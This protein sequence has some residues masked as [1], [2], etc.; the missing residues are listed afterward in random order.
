MIGFI[1]DTKKIV[2]PNLKN[3]YPLENSF[4]DT[5]RANQSLTQNGT[6]PF[7]TRI[8]MPDGNKAAGVFSDANYLSYT[9]AN[10]TN[11]SSYFI[12]MLVHPVSQSNDPIMVDNVFATNFYLQGSN[13]NSRLQWTWGTQTNTGA[14]TFQNGNW[15]Y[16]A[17]H[18]VTGSANSRLWLS[19]AN[20]IS[21]TPIATTNFNQTIGTCSDSRF[22]RYQPS[23]GFAFNGYIKNIGVAVNYSPTRL[24]LNRG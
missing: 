23:T 17:M 7:T 10:L 8:A 2:D 9:A 3:F 6:V 19:L 1:N 14:N 4:G 11:A 24:P 13:A 5:Q 18:M 21:Q 12:E 20:N 16:I 15:Y 22:G